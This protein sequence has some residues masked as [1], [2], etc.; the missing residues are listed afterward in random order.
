MLQQRTDYVIQTLTPPSYGSGT[1]REQTV[2]YLSG[3][4]DGK[5]RK[6][7]TSEPLGQASD[8]GKWKAAKCVKA[9]GNAPR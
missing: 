8:L 6:S 1:R 7:D 2:R 3:R 9:W 5:T 4:G